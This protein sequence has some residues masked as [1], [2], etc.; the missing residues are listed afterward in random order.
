MSREIQIIV[1]WL[2]G[3]A[4]MWLAKSKRRK[5]QTIPDWIIDFLI[6]VIVAA[7]IIVIEKLIF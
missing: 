3:M 7:V 1:A 5:S 2:I 4:A 6:V